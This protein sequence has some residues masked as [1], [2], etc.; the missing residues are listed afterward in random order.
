MEKAGLDVRTLMPTTTDL[1][2]KALYIRW[3]RRP[4]QVT[5]VPT[6]DDTPTTNWENV[7][8]TKPSLL[9]MTAY[10]P[11]KLKANE[12]ASIKAPAQKITKLYDPTSLPWQW[13]LLQMAQNFRKR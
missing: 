11:K 13:T 1:I 7:W 3:E 10:A 2:D 4:V 12:V 8:T 9:D 5:N 6:T